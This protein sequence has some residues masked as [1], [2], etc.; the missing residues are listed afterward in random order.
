MTDTS[1]RKQSLASKLKNRFSSKWS[2]KG[3]KDQSIAAKSDADSANKSV[4]SARSGIE[5]L[6]ANLK[7]SH[8]SNNP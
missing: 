3:R 6:H 1:R 5:Q 4:C 7:R 8:V 2:N